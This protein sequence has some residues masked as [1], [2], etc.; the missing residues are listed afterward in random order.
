VVAVAPVPTPVSSYR[1]PDDLNLFHIPSRIFDQ[2][3]GGSWQFAGLTRLLPLPESL[4]PIDKVRRLLPF[5]DY[6]LQVC[7]VV[8]H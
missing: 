3:V 7:V 4:Y 1:N 5:S 6:W 8:C 2:G